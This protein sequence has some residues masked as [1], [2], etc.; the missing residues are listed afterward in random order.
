MAF[1]PDGTLAFADGKGGIDLWDPATKSVIA[2]L[3]DPGGRG[4]MS[5]AF[6]K[7]GTLAAADADGSI[8]LWDTATKAVTATLT[9]AGIDEAGTVA[10]GPNDM[11]AVGN[12]TNGANGQTYV[13]NTAA[14]SVI[15]VLTDPAGYGVTSMAFGP[16]GTLAVGYFSGGRGLTYSK[17]HTY[18]WDTATKSIVA[19]LNDPDGKLVDDVAFGPDGILAVADSNGRTYLWNTAT[20]RVTATFTDPDGAATSVA[21]GP[22]GTLAV[23]N[24]VSSQGA[25]GMTVATSAYVWNTTTRNIVTTITDPGRFGVQGLAFGPD[26]SLAVADNDGSIYLWRVPAK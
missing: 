3:T 20:K 5:L 12:V 6:R 1:G 24:A 23:G 19:T 11:L 8:Y 21:F 18:L 7:D 13:F 25:F 9:D 22:N 14:G 10:F 2:T 26:G 16:D 15:G 17:G 4:P